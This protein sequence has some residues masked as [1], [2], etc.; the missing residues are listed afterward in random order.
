MKEHHRMET[1]KLK[2]HK[3]KLRPTVTNPFYWGTGNREPGTRNRE[4]QS[5]H[6]IEPEP[7]L[8]FHLK[9]ARNQEPWEP[10]PKG[11]NGFLWGNRWF[12]I[13]LYEMGTLSLWSLRRLLS[14]FESQNALLD[15]LNVSQGHR[16]SWGSWKVSWSLSLSWSSYETWYKWF[17]FHSNN[18]RYST[19]FMKGFMKFMKPFFPWNIVS[20]SRLS[21]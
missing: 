9:P 20:W 21:I 3:K 5:Y 16:T 19:C 7:V 17:V 14:R 12:S 8:I 6:I 13:G 1:W 2:F 10:E 4:P 15:A 11:V 18:S